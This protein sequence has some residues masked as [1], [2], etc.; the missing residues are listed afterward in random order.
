LRPTATYRKVTGGF[1]S[2]WG[3]DL[4][5]AVR[6]VGGTAARRGLDAYQA[7]RAVLEGI[8]HSTVLSRYEVCNASG[9]LTRGSA[10]TEAQIEEY[11]RLGSKVLNLPG[12]EV[13]TYL[14]GLKAHASRAHARL[15]STNPS[16][17]QR[18][19]KRGYGR[20]GEPALDRTE[21]HPHDGRGGHDGRGSDRGL[22]F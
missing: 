10:E 15:K 8:R 14:D 11:W 1:R 2:N 20:D 4:F 6:S 17:F 16:A 3:A 18:L 22:Y 12:N 19:E 13:S 5:A 9:K 21:K 7:I